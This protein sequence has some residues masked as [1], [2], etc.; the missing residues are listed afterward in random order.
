MKNVSLTRRSF[1]TATAVTGV[2]AA[3]TTSSSGM[4]AALA[5]SPVPANAG[6]I[7]R[8]RSSCRGCGKMECGVWVTVKDGRAIKIEGD[9]SCFTSRGNCCTKSMSSLQACYHPDRLK[10]PMKRTRPKGEDPGWVRISWAEALKTSRRKLQEVQAKYG[11]ESVFSMCGTSRV[12]SMAPY[13]AIGQLLKTPNQVVGLQICKGPRWLSGQLTNTFAGSWMSTVDRPKV[14]VQWAGSSEISNYD[15]SCRTTVDAYSE[16]KHYINVNP[17]LSNAGT[18]ADIWLP[19]RPGTDAALAL[20]W[21]DVMIRHKLYDELFCKRWTNG[22]F[23]YCHDIQPSGFE[24]QNKMLKFELKTR[25][26]KESDIKHGG[27]PKKFMVW[28]K[29]ANRLTY[30][31][32]ETGLWE[33]EKF[34]RPTKGTHVQGG[35]LPEPSKF[36][37][38]IDPALFGEF[39]VKLKDGRSVKVTPVFQLLAN[40]AAEYT[41]VK[42]EK[43]TGVPA[44]KIELAAKTWATR[45]DPRYPNGGIQYM[46]GTEQA[47]NSTQN[48]RALSVLVAING[49]YDTPAGNRGP[50]MGAVDAS[51]GN[52]C[53]SLPSPSFEK[54][55][56]GEKFPLLKW[57]QWWADCASVW[58]AVH[59]GKPYPLKAAICESGNFF[60]HGNTT[61]AWEGLKKLEFFLDIDLWHHPT[62]E[63]ADIILPACHW[64]EVDAPR[65]SQGGSGGMGATCKCVEPLAEAKY[66]VEFVDLLFK[67]FGEE[68]LPRGGPFP[69][70]V[71]GMLDFCVAG[72]KMNWKTYKAKFQK[73]GW[74]DVKKFFPDEWGTYRRYE[75]GHLRQ[76]PA[77]FLLPGDG[78]PGFSTPTMKTEIW[79]TILETFVPGQNMELPIFLEPPQGPVSTPNLMKEYPLTMITGRRIPVYFHSEHRQLPWCRELWPVPK[80]EIHPE[81]A[82]KLGLKQGDWAWIESP[83]GKVRQ[84]VDIYVGIAPNVINAE[85]SWWFPEMPAPE[86]GF[87]YSAINQLVNPH[88]QDP[89]CGSSHLRGYPVKVYK[90]K[91]GAPEGIIASSQDKRLKKWKPVHEGRA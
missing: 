91:E 88:A 16:A 85:H 27:D 74:Y 22:P 58:D 60:S 73:D 11:N 46:L 36:D 34:K 76:P 8:I 48:T 28:D 49:A 90:A 33:G 81:T 83:F 20:S 6:K 65:Q 53:P 19:L 84:T 61:E 45:I 52:F 2:A 23:L 39:P 64:L 25:L 66:D 75:T 63:M 87:K 67:E 38:K 57:W 47:G 1:L 44:A 31:S 30:F 70:T 10:Y 12:Y 89:I 9:E 80:M 82:A 5:Y 42:A 55:V 35:F 40:R 3:F 26:L 56:G 71:E 78:K 24:C 29:L 43:V 15:D 50:T 79:S 17:R 4:T 41:P 54:V 18:Q 62:S 72:T 37:P 51:P 59:T 68:F 14:Y 7:E 86:H 32:A 77:F 21:M 13:N 69:H